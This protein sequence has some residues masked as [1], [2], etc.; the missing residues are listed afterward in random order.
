VSFPVERQYY[1]V[2]YPAAE[3]PAFTPASGAACETLDCSEQ[4]LRYQTGPAHTLPRVGTVVR[5]RVHFRRGAEV[6][7]EGTVV[8]VRDGEVV[9]CLS[10]GAGV[11]L[12]VILAEQQY[13]R[14]HFAGR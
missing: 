12:S 1:R 10:P 11:P 9:L 7:V 5:G 6:S 13:L 2:H 4:G 3:R 8:R 14:T